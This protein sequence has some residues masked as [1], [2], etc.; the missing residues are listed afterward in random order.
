MSD[1]ATT[2][3]RHRAVDRAVRSVGVRYPIVQTGMG[4]VSGARLTAATSRPAVSA[5]SPSATMTL[6][7]LR[8]AITKVKE[9]TDEPVRREPPRRPA[10]PGAS[11]SPDH[12][13]RACTV[14]SF[15]G[16]PAP[17][18]VARAARRRRRHDRPPS[19]P[20]ATPRRC[21]EMGRRRRDRPGRRGRR[22]HRHRRHL[23]AAAPGRRRGRR[24][25][26]PRAR[27]R[28][29]LRRARPRRPRSPTAPTASPWAPASCSPQESHVPDTRQGD[30]P[31]HAGRPARS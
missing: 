20:V 31:R 30:L 5:S 25:R 16:A 6:D 3:G 11:A 21:A 8:A 14:A 1:A 10:R 4:W 28:R 13:A 15:A 23:A 22:P 24:Y 17:E 26:R 2:A 7:E 29:L 9:R 12:L 19:A 18:Q 27:R